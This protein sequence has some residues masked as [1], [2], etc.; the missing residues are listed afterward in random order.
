MVAVCEA[1]AERHPRDDEAALE[2][3]RGDLS[4]GSCLNWTR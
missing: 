2:V 3:A 1:G 4:L